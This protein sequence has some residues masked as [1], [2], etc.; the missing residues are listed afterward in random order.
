MSSGVQVDEAIDYFRSKS[1]Y[2]QLFTLFRKKLISLGRCGGTIDLS[3]FSENDIEEFALFLGTSAHHLVEKNRIK[4]T[5][6]EDRLQQTRFAPL[7][8]HALLEAYFDEEIRSER[9]RAERKRQQQEVMLVALKLEFPALEKWFSHLEGRSPDTY[10]VRRMMLDRS[11][12]EEVQLLHLAYRSLP[13]TLE[14]YPFFSQRVTG[15]PH[16]FDLTTVRGKLWLHLLQVM[17]DHEGTITLQTEQMNDLL[18]SVNLLRDDIANF[19]TASNLLGYTQGIANPVLRAAM[20]NHSVLNLPLRELLKLDEMKTGI[21]GSTVFI[22]E[23]SGVFSALIDVVPDVPLICTHGQFKLAGLRLMD[24]LVESG[25]S[26][27]YAGDFDPEGIAMA[28]RFQERYGHM[29]KLWRMDVQSYHHS[30]PTTDL[31]E[32]TSKLVR[33]KE[34]VLGTLV[35]E[36]SVVGKA[37]YQESIIDLYIEDLQRFISIHSEKT[38]Q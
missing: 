10:W 9:V 23:N 7:T 32:R 35:S 15:N 3:L 31:G 34:S 11:F 30:N 38:V 17:K 21:A 25:H 33:L 8:L 6:F 2:D 36:L 26:L 29:G 27:C 12:R 5:D 19:V 13:E 37:G 14:R 4:C 16:S 20:A 1:G 24:L 28:V 22:V 18:L